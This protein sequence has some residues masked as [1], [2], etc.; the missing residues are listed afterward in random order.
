[1]FILNIVKYDE[2]Y[3]VEYDSYKIIYSF[4]GD[5]NMKMEYLL[6]LLVSRNH[7]RLKYVQYIP[8]NINRAP[9]RVR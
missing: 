9:F 4:L 8:Y 7:V 2:Q 3:D 1:M 5:Q 6:Y